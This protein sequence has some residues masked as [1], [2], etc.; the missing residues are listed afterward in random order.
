MSCRIHFEK[1]KGKKETE[2]PQQLLDEM[3]LGSG[4]AKQ[5]FLSISPRQWVPA[6]GRCYLLHPEACS[7]SCDEHVVGS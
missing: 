2:W 3:S 6:V 4:T 5:P 7:P 1:T